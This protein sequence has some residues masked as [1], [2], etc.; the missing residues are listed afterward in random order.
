MASQ[1]RLFVKPMLIKCWASV[2]DV[3]PSGMAFRLTNTGL[4]LSQRLRDWGNIEPALV[5]HLELA[6]VSRWGGGGTCQIQ[7]PA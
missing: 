1:R 7:R 2:A 5:Q 6:F 4:M 3:G